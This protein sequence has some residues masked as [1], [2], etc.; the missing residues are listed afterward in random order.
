[1][2]EANAKCPGRSRT[3]II[4]GRHRMISCTEHNHM[5]DPLR[6][7]TTRY[8][9]ALKRKALEGNEQPE[10]IIRLCAA[11]FPVEV[12]YFCFFFSLEYAAIKTAS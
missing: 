5:P 1:M 7:E 3:E 9:V 8:R 11:Q 12:K 4:D 2:Q 10:K 6:A